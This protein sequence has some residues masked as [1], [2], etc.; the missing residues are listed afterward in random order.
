M[1]DLNV[2]RSKVASGVQALSEALRA[3]DAASAAQRG[4]GEDQGLTQHDFVPWN[5]GVDRL[6]LKLEYGNVQ[7]L[8]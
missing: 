2:S 4:Y 5:G 8:S 7:N 1:V 3:I 6:L